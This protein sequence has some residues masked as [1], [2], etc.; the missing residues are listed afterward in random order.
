[1]QT[2]DMALIYKLYM[3][4]NKYFKKKHPV[5]LY[6]ISLILIIANYYVLCDLYV[7]IVY[8]IFNFGDM[9]YDPR[10][11]RLF[12]IFLLLLTAVIL[13]QKIKEPS[14][15]YN[16]IYFIILIIPASVLSV[17][18]G[19]NR[20]HFFL[21]TAALW[22][23]ILIQYLIK[24]I[25]KNRTVEINMGYKYLP[26]R[27]VL[28][29]I[30]ITLVF[31]VLQV[32]GE[33]NFN[34]SEV[35]AY[36]FDI[37]S[38]MPFALRYLLSIAAISLVG[39]CS[40]LALHRKDFKLLFLIVIT[41]VLYFGFSSHKAMLF[42]PLA[43][44]AL[45]YVLKLP[46]PHLIIII[47]ICVLSVVTIIFTSDEFLTLGSMFA[48]RIIF[49]P[50]QINFHYFDYFSSNPHMLWAESKISFGLLES[51][52][53]MSVMNYIGG[54]MTGDYDV[55]ANTGWVANAY[56]NAGIIGISLYA[57]IVSF[58]Y[59]LIDHWSKIYGMRFVCS[60]FLIPVTTFI[61]SSDLLIT[62]LTGG[63][64]FLLLI[65]EVTTFNIR[66]RGKMHNTP[67][68]VDK[69]VEKVR[70]KNGI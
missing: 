22:M 35:Y 29:I 8:P 54:L 20:F 23:L 26:Y 33:F 10:G 13:P 4:K 51:E 18:Q 66:L 37:S 68:R 28:F 12:E 19:S 25:L 39:Y 17:E 50:N 67:Q 15:I 14:D 11:N 1:M 58:L 59:F 5:F 43:V 61:M 31:L 53:P 9:S 7:K 57:V 52:L 6:I 34:I 41:G 60:A 32:R 36:R 38:N 46:R 63:L 2:L 70:I 16:W 65:F 42:Y 56:M 55:G 62:L 64:I 3:R 69:G 48:N 45:Y 40:A 44:I 30:I 47:C 49:L 24:A 21:M 27:S